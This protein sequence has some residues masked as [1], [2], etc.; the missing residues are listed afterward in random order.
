MKL[1]SFIILVFIGNS[2]YSQLA[3][4]KIQSPDSLEFYIH[5]DDFIT[6]DTSAVA[7]EF[8]F[9]EIF[10]PT[11]NIR[12]KADSLTA[13]SFDLN[14]SEGYLEIY[15]ITEIGS[16]YL[17]VPFLKTLI[18]Q[19]TIIEVID[20]INQNYTKRVAAIIPDNIGCKSPSRNFN[21][22]F[23]K[24]KN[25]TFSFKKEKLIYSYLDKNCLYVNQIQSLIQ[26]IDYED[27]KIDL[28]KT[29]YKNTYDIDNF[30]KLR[31][32]FLLEKYQ[33]LFD[34]FVEEIN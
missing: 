13:I 32:M 11:G 28:L 1:F 15:E 9:Q 16:S 8:S 25:N 33:I 27:K 31:S 4:L 18:V 7:F 30:I 2:V 17:I 23:Q 12:L 5:I 24:I 26:L 3:G 20:N 29:A 21:F 22:E 6:P 14:L 10:Q 19:D 34:E